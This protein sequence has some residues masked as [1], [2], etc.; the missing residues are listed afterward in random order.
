MDFDNNIS[1]KSLSDD[2]IIKWVL[3]VIND[4]FKQYFFIPCSNEHKYD[5]LKKII[6]ISRN[7]YDGQESYS[8]Y[9]RR[10]LSSYLNDYIK[11]LFDKKSR[12]SIMLLNK[13][14]ESLHG[15]NSYEDAMDII[16]ILIE[17]T[18]KYNYTINEYMVFRLLGYSS[19]FVTI[20]N[21]CVNEKNSSNDN[22][23]IKLITETYYE[24]LN[25]DMYNAN[26]RECQT[27]FNAYIKEVTNIPLL[28]VDEEKKLMYDYKNGDLE[29]RDKIIESNLRMV[30]SIARKYYG[31]GLLLEDLIQEGNIGLVEA[32]INYDIEKNIKFS[33]YA[34]YWIK[35]EIIRAIKN[36]S[37]LIRLPDYAYDQMLKFKKI[38]KKLEVE[39][40][41]NVTVEEMANYL[42]IPISKATILFN[43]IYEPASLNDFANDEDEQE[44]G[45]IIITDD[46]IPDEEMMK[47]DYIDVVQDM[48]KDANLSERELNIL[49]D[50]Y[51][52]N[53][54]RETLANLSKKY[55]VSG[56]YISFIEQRALKKIKKMDRIKEYQMYFRGKR[57]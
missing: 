1:I 2:E 56:A 36:K 43:S 45:E 34:Y 7:N 20:A 48:L 21:Y 55:G 4:V 38:K 49:Y 9:F 22:Y 10:N 11:Q 30:V 33:T 39:L 46:F 57:K 42:K 24:K 12:A 27:S 19:K 15:V 53:G 23:L 29:A 3:P 47:K 44:K 17:F 37:K 54:D 50:R 26:Y 51:G 32:L 18:S 41:R 52:F 13:Y 5:I 8:V 14:L 35:R 31:H 16:N 40:M 6:R 28:T 25:N